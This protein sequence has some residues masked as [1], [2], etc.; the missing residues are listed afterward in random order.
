M[1]LL[2]TRRC[3]DG[4]ARLHRKAG[5]VV[6]FELAGVSQETASGLAVLQGA[7]AGG[8]DDARHQSARA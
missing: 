2:L 7:E 3:A 8:D 6:L 4:W 5:A 1:C